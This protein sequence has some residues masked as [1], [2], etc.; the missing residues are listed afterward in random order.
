MAKTYT[1]TGTVTGGQKGSW[2]SAYWSLFYY[3]GNRF[4]GRN[5]SS[6]NFFASNIVF[7]VA[8]LAAL[9]NSVVTS[10]KLTITVASGR[11]YA[12]GAQQWAIGYKKTPYTGTDVSSSDNTKDPWCRSNSSSTTATADTIGYVTSNSSSSVSASNTQFTYDL[13]SAGVPVYGYVIGPGIGANQATMITLGS[14]ATLTV[15]VQE[16]TVSYNKGSYGTGTNVSDT[17]TQNVALTLRSAIFTRTGYTQT[18]WSRNANGSTLDYGLGASYT[19]N[20]DITL[21]PYWTINTYS[22]SYNKGSYGSGSNVSD[23]KTYG[24]TL[25]LRG[26][27]FTR[28][29]YEQ[30]GWATSDGG[31]AVYDLEG[32]YTNN[33]SITLYPVWTINTY[34]VSYNKGANGTGTNVTDTKTYNVSVSLRGAIFTRTGYT[35]SGWSTTDGGSLAY[36]LGA[37]YTSNSSITLYPYWTIN[38]YTISYD[39][40]QYGQGTNSTATKTY[41]TPITLKGAV[42]TRVGYTQTGWSTTDGGAKAYDLLASYTANSSTTLYPYWTINTYTVSF[43]A[44]GGSDAP[45]AQTKTY[46]VDLTLS[47]Q[48]PVRDGYTFLGWATTSTATAAEYQPSGTYTANQSTILYAVWQENDN[49]G[50]LRYMQA[51]GTLKEAPLYYMTQNGLVQAALYVMQ[52]DGTLKLLS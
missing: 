38:T 28:T 27:I 24:T 3:S 20:A 50:S 22:V 51:D 43:D 21:Y 14:S 49:G 6:G 29:G 8:T 17:K 5:G 15:V 52:Q 18:G 1:L 44:N 16:Y 41:N 40:G 4:V 46:G 30:T 12:D 11:V 48:T 47:S 32:S 10:V 25:K 37:S 19:T 9:R 31:S 34:L 35:Q 13:T 36:N 42:F 39:K 7:D 2:G 45:S 23:T 26:A 33:A